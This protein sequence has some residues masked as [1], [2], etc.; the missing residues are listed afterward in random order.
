MALV[1]G[2]FGAFTT[3]GLYNYVGQDLAAGTLKS[4]TTINGL[5]LKSAYTFSSTHQLSDLTPQELSGGSYVRSTSASVFT[6]SYDATS[7]EYRFG[8]LTPQLTW[9]AFTG[10]WQYVVAFNSSNNH[11][12][13]CWGLAQAWA[14]AGSAFSLR[15]N[16]NPYIRVVPS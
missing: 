5:L 6:I 15:D 11:P 13:I 8:G 14:N 4:T 3:Q 1:T 2:K 10:T 7:H 9:A 12:Y 16:G